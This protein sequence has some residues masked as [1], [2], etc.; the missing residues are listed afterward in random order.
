MSG[1]FA[2]AGRVAVRFRWAVI[3]AWV[4]ATVLANLYL[5]SLDSVAKGS[6]SDYLPAGS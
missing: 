3:A 2:A 6:T 4:V 1:F 5:P